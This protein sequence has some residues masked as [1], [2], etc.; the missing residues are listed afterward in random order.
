[1]A[2]LDMIVTS[3]QSKIEKLVH[4]HKK[5]EDENIKL[6]LENQDLLKLVEEQERQL[7]ELD[8]KNRTLTIAS[9]LSDIKSIGN[10][11][12]SKLKINELVREID[13]C[14]ALLNK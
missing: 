3:L 7:K 9:A 2:D 12:E 4:L 8:E 13:K 11:T 10:A 6:V 14:I 1:M 5:V